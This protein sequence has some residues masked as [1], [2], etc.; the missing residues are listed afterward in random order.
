MLLEQLDR[1]PQEPV[2]SAGVKSCELAPV[3]KR[4]ERVENRGRL[5]MPNGAGENHGARAPLL[6]K[7]F[8]ALHVD[9]IDESI[10]SVARRRGGE[11]AKGEKRRRLSESRT[12]S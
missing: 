11:A 6:E 2:I 5:R 12:G 9:E 3:P 8:R 4:G 10:G 1:A 7:E